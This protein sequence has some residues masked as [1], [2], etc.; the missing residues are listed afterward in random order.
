LALRAREKPATATPAACA[1][2]CRLAEA[3]TVVRVALAGATAALR[4]RVAIV[5]VL[6]RV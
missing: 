6:V 4:I 3:F 1:I 2:L 5:L